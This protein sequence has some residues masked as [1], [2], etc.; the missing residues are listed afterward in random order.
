MRANG[1]PRELLEHST[2]PEVQ[3]FLTRGAAAAAPAGTEPSIPQ[4]A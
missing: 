3:Q 4:P 2:D 1:N